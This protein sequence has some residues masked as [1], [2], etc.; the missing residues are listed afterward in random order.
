M[1]KSK[2][3]E[4]LGT[5]TRR[6]W[7]SFQD[8][9]QSPYFNRNA[10][11]I[12]L[13][14]WL[15]NKAPEFPGITRQALWA[16]VYPGQPFDNRQLNHLMSWLLKSAE[17]F[18]GLEYLNR[19]NF[20]IEWQTGA[21]LLA[22][23]LDKH[24]RF[25]AE[26]LR[27]QLQFVPYR[28]AAHFLQRYRLADLELRAHM[29]QVT[30]RQSDDHLQEASDQLDFFYLTEKLKYA[31]AMLNNQ[32]II[33]SAYQFHFVEEVRRFVESHP[34]P[35]EAP[36]VAVYFRIF[37]MLTKENGDADFRELRQLLRL[38]GN[39]FPHTEMAWL[40]GYALNYCIRQIRNVREEFVPEALILYEQGIKSGILLGE[41]GSLSPWHFKNIVKLALRLKRYEWTEHF[42]RDNYR[43]LEEEFRA[44]ALHY[45]LADL[46]FFTGRYG[47]AME[48]LIQVEFTDVHYNLGAKE[49]LAKIYYETGTHEALESLLHA[50]KI[51]LQRNRIITD[52]VRKAY[53]NFIKLL[54]L[55]LRAT[56]D[57]LPTLRQRIEKTDS[58]TAKN[59]LLEQATPASGINKT[60]S[61]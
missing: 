53:L 30:I 33:S 9:L 45:N 18:L 3:L 44:D 15:S 47:E 34:L 26:R 61:R 60:H 56:S 29:D 6:E 11:L 5:L 42:I 24:Y 27:R 20:E 37:Q 25:N 51:Y 10:D 17:H 54:R 7:H 22:R 48:H 1:K 8:F 12:R 16:T 58:L 49:M 21:A 57:Q 52:D 43:L 39:R 28:D 32:A 23:G 19:N 2:L 46:Y 38:H 13:A 41:N 59:W 55:R 36:G 4:L 50:F 35:P 14:G 40:Y 31:C